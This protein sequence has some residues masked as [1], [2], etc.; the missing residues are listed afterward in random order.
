MPI[1]VMGLDLGQAQDFTANVICE[2][3]GT[4]YGFG[5]IGLPMVRCDVRYIDRYN[6]G[7]RYED[8]A[9]D[10]GKRLAKVPKPH[11]LVVD[12]TGVGRPVMEMLSYLGPHGITITGSG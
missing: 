12:E 3:E 8:I 6:L 9:V 4:Q 1:F 7:T 2:A 10:V 5:L 11:Y